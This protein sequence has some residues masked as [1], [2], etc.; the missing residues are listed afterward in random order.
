M[1]VS[2]EANIDYWGKPVLKQ[3]L[4]LAKKAWYSPTDTYMR[5][6]NKI[7]LKFDSASAADH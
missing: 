5:C 6:Y 4:T 1:K 7:D 3:I 2:L